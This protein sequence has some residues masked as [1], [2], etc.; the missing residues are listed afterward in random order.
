MKAV[1]DTELL[2]IDRQTIGELIA[3][4]PIVLTVLCRCLRTRLVESLV[5]TSSLFAPF[6]GEEGT[7]LINRFQLLE[8][9]AGATLIEEGEKAPGLFVVMSG[10]LDVARKGSMAAAQYLTTLKRGDVF[11]EMSLLARTGAAATVRARTKCLILELP[12]KAFREIIMT[13]PRVLAYVGDLAAEREQKFSE[14]E[15][16][17]AQY[18]DLHLDLF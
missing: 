1:V 8:V 9:E 16:G 17:R 12:D 6:N 2:A 14:L 15:Q 5:K 7:K 10:R 3:S 11:G 13:H 4:E 18:E